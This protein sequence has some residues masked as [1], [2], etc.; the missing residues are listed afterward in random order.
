MDAFLVLLAG[1]ILG[2]VCIV[3]NHLIKMHKINK[4]FDRYLEDLN[5][6]IK[7]NNK[8]K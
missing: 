6:R 4:E 5:R 8:I 3:V 2:V 7:T 1:A